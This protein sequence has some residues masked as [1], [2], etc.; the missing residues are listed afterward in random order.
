[1]D[2]A[3]RQ[4]GVLRRLQQDGQV[5]VTDLAA[6]FETAEITIRRDLE[7]LAREGVLRR[8]RGGAISLL[9][10]RDEL[11][12][13]VR[14]NEHAAAKRRIGRQAASLIG[15]GETVILDS[16]TTALE[17]ARNLA[18]RRMTVM[19]LSLPAAMIL[20]AFPDVH[21]ILPGVDVRSGEQGC[22]GSLAL[23]AIASMR[24]DTFVM[25]CCAC[26]VDR[27]VTAY[28]LS[29]ASI[30]RAAMTASGRV[31]LIADSD[32]FTRSSPAVICDLTEIDTLITD[33]DLPSTR[34]ARIRQVIPEVLRV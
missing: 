25:S 13:G 31:V 12:F 15:A 29:D 7:H 6:A 5:S 19:P 26:D 17:V 10:R 30:K 3:S 1:M 21:L 22:S 24:F 9:T 14:V 23:S 27:G 11:P 20:A 32:K 28:D 8:V 16:G 4:A 34:L 18:E 33:T 2:T